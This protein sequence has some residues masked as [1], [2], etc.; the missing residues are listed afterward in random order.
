[1]IQYMRQ[2]AKAPRHRDAG[3]FPALGEGNSSPSYF[4]EM[5]NIKE[6][7]VFIDE[8]GSFSSYEADPNSPHYLLCMV[9]HNQDDDISEEESKLQDSLQNMGLERAHTIHAGPL[10]RR[11]D[12]YANM[13]REKRIGVFRRMMIFIQKAKFKYR[14]FRIYKPYHTNQDAIHDIL[15]QAMLDFLVA[16]RDELN[17]CDGIKI[18]YDN[19][20]SQVTELLKEAFAMFS[21]KVCFVPQVSPNRYRLFQVADVACTLELTRAKL[22]EKERISISEDKF[23]GG[24]KD[25]KKLYLKPLSKKLWQ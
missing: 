25:L 22:E 4:L 13:T 8:S 19:G 21:P 12:D 6:I 1:M 5:A 18:Y 20:Q 10:I 7:S 11:E 23:F 15:L 24:V 9:V 14:C 17:A 16:H 2:R 3:N